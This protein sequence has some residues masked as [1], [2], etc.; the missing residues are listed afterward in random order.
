[1]TEKE[2]RLLNKLIA[3]AGWL[4]RAY[5]K[6]QTTETSKMVT[7]MR[8]ANRAIDDA[9]EILADGRPNA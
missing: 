7:A 5:N 6:W 9:M 8:E 1:M 2:D 3:S 4:T